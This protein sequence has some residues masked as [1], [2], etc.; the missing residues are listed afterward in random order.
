MTQRLGKDTDTNLF[1]RVVAVM[2]T[3]GLYNHQLCRLPQLNQCITDVAGLCR[4]QFRAPGTDTNSRWVRHVSLR[5]LIFGGF[6]NAFNDGTTVKTILLKSLHPPN[7]ALYHE[8]CGD[9]GVSIQ[10]RG[11]R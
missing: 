9:I 8:I 2:V 7:S 10:A 5:V 11:G 4:G 1:H 3:G 6:S